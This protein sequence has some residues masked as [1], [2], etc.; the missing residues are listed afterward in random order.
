MWKNLYIEGTVGSENGIILEEDEE[1]QFYE[2]FTR[3]Y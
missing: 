3:K 1:Y 2:E